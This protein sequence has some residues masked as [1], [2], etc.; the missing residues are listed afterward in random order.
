MHQPE[1]TP[2]LEVEELE[3]TYSTREGPVRAVWGVCFLRCHRGLNEHELTSPPNVHCRSRCHRAS[4]AFAGQASQALT[5]C[6][7]VVTVHPRVRKW[8]RSIDK[9]WVLLTGQVLMIERSESP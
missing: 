4:R 6:P 3:V 9:A 1:T 5:W 7:R 8:H 2:V